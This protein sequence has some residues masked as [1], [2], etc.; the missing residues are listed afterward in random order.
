M[1]RGSHDFRRLTTFPNSKFDQSA[2]PKTENRCQVDHRGVSE[3]V[4][5]QDLS[6]WREALEHLRRHGRRVQGAGCRVQGAGCEVQGAGCGVWGVIGLATK[7]SAAGEKHCSIYVVMVLPA[8]NPHLTH[9]FGKSFRKNQFPH[10]FVNF[11]DKDL[12]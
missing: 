4:S 11:V 9:F 12:R 3:G 6:L 1:L 5:H 8:L 7:I 2:K 10:K